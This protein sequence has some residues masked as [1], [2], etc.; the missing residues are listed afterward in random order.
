MLTLWRHK[1]DFDSAG[2]NQVTCSKDSVKVM[3]WGDGICPGVKKG[4]QN[5]QQEILSV[6]T[7]VR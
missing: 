1:E 2:A 5:T 7:M 6:D 3:V 4:K